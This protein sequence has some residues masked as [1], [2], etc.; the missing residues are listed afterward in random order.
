MSLHQNVTCIY[1][2][3]SKADRRIE[4]QNNLK[5]FNLQIKIILVRRMAFTCIVMFL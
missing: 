4:D 1:E 3:F 5:F 2:T